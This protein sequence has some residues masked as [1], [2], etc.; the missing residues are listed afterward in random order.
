M[1]A[2]A[3]KLGQLILSG[4]NGRISTEVRIVGEFFGYYRIEA[5]TFTRLAGHCRYLAPGK[6]VFIPKRAIWVDDH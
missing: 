5:I 6:R 4:P 3:M 2:K 1:D